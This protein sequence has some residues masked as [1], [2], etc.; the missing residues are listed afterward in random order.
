MHTDLMLWRRYIEVDEKSILIT[1]KIHILF[2]AG[3]LLCNQLKRILLS[4]N[5]NVSVD[6]CSVIV[7][8]DT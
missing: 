1:K 7:R 5:A 4:I 6:I 2:H 8:N 3:K